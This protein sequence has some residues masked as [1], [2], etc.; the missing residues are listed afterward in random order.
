MQTHFQIRPVGEVDD[1]TYALLSVMPN[2]QCIVFIHGYSGKP[3]ETWAEFDRLLPQESCCTGVDVFFYGYD[4][5]FAEMAA[6]ASLFADFLE[7][8][9]AR[10][11]SMIRRALP[12]GASREADFR[13]DRV[14]LVAHSLGAVVTRWALLDLRDRGHRGL[15]AVSMVLFAPAHKGA[16]VQALANEVLGGFSFTRILGAGARFQSPLVDQLAVGSRELESLEARTTGSVRE[17]GAR[18]YLVPRCIVI[19][20]FEKIVSNLRFASDGPPRAFR[21]ATHMNVCKPRDSWRDPLVVVTEV[22]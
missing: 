2:R 9:L 17:D 15:D 4:G 10:P 13:Y 3:L 20:E 19:A 6:S 21:R 7:S 22:I 11:M 16:R 5:L 18:S 12:P 8:I 14:L 1:E